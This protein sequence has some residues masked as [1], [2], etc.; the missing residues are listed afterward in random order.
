MP[1]KRDRRRQ[2][3]GEQTPASASAAR[4][5][6]GL[7]AVLERISDAVVALDRNWRYI[8]V[9]EKAARIFGRTPADL[10]GKHIWTE[11]PEGVGQPFH[12]AY[13][14]ALASGEPEFLEEYYPPYDR[15]FEN[16]I[17]PSGDGLT[18]Y[19]QDVTARKKDESALRARVQD[20]EITLRS[21]GD[22]VIVTDDAGRI[23]RLNPAAQELTGWTLTDAVGRPLGDVLRLVRPGTREP[24]PDVATGVLATNARMDL[25]NDV[26]LL[27]RDGSERAIADSA[28]PV[29]DDGGRATGVVVVLSDQT[30]RYAVRQ[31][32]AESEERLRL[33]LRS[34]NQGLYDLNVQTGDAT[35][36]AEYATMLGYDPA[37]F[38]ETNAS[39]I[40]RLHPDDREPVARAYRDY[41]GGKTAEYRVEFRQR[42]A[43]GRWRWILSIGSIVARGEGGEPLR[44][45]GTHTDITDRKEAEESLRRNEQDLSITLQSIGDAVISTDGHGRIMRMNATAERLTGWSISEARGRALHE[46]FCIVHSATREPAADPVRRVLATGAMVAMANHTALLSRTGS[47]F[48]IADSA[49]PIREADGSIVGVVLVFSDV[50]QRY[51]VEQALREREARLRTIIDTE[52]ECVKV[53]SPEGRLLEM[54]A[55]GLAMLEA[56]SLAEVQV[57]QLVDYIVPAY[58]KDFVELHRRVMRGET[59]V[60]EF[61]VVG[62]KG[63]PRWLETHAAPLVDPDRGQTTLLGVTRDITERKR[64]EAER[65]RMES[66]LRTAERMEAVGQLAGG[67]AHDF[68]NLL[69]VINSMAELAMEGL[70][71]GDPVRHDLAEIRRAGDRAAALTAQLLALSR[72]QVVAP[73]TLDVGAVV[74]N[75]R[76]MLSRVVR[77]DV[78]L[79]V[80]LADDMLLV[81][82]DRGQLERVIMNLTVNARDAMPRGGTLTITTAMQTLGPE[83]AAM[84]P[85]LMPGRYARLSLTDTGEGIPDSARQHIFEPFFTTKL[86]GRGTGLGLSS[87]FGIVVQSRGAMSVESTPGH[88]STFHVYLPLMEG[89]IRPVDSAPALAAVPRGSETILIVDDEEALVRVAKRMLESAG[90][91]TLTATSGDEALR[92]A[93]H[94]GG[95]LHL[96]VTDVVMPGMGGPELATRLLARHPEARVLFTSGYPDDIALRDA[97]KERTEQLLAK[98]YATHELR[99]MVREVLDQ[100]RGRTS[101]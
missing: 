46:V 21:I 1:A 86:R 25:S 9:N 5:S 88:G 49:A 58:R 98:P 43:D 52:P 91:L 87:S 42:T 63:T 80:Q 37:A 72:N 24:V 65:S 90:Y 66:Q 74:T 68:N 76:P 83:A 32:L 61:E 84:T 50:T 12:L 62:L 55:A 45:L 28:A 44:M 54:N 100:S 92:L 3:H 53:V 60:L 26:L 22:A 78:E 2:P 75:V 99:R 31:A 8:Y 64:A 34:A 19:F 94:L 89:A 40:E 77:E 79:R 96:L 10:V 33:A 56:D 51:R 27:R 18:I 41:I 48:Q 35:V 93:E 57:K 7:G 23:T 4:L 71:A 59:G 20:L 69:S 36:T 16:R 47:E 17:Y 13:E 97:I 15:W 39:W 82:A 6:E 29:R 67:V 30:S 38:R 81:H 73:E 95:P 14:R 11:F 70:P 85:P 101:A